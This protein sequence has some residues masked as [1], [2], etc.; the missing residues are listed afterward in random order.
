MHSYSNSRVTRKRHNAAR[1]TAIILPFEAPP[2]APRRRRNRKSAFRLDHIRRREIERLAR[3]VG[4]VDTEDLSRYLI[5]WAWHNRQSTD[6]IWAIRNAARRMGRPNLTDA[7]ASAII[8]EASTIRGYLSADGVAEFLRVS[9]A[10][11]QALGLTT[12][13]AVNVK[14]RDRKVIRRIRDKVK[15]EQ[16][17]RAA[18]VRPRAE[19]EA[20]SLSRTKPWRAVNMSR[21]T[22]E[23]HR[24]K[25]RDA[26]VSAARLLIAEE[27][28]ASAR[29]T[30]PVLSHRRSKKKNRGGLPSRDGD[31]DAADRYV[32]AHSSLP[33][34]LR[35]LALGLQ[36]EG[37]SANVIT[38][39]DPRMV[40][41]M[42]GAA[43]GGAR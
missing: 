16:K 39:D 20:T 41:R 32:T 8:E 19:Y 24:N 28:L 11:R 35:L 33:L 43:Y 29:P 9:Y 25:A 2:P 27:G 13:G 1:P 14:R 5:A 22:W 17:R 42:A 15:R 4:A 37:P 3:H 30:E 34:E 7:E 21:R 6:P 38:A 12:I 31:H 36:S 18:G 23:R 10:K 40:A 26:S